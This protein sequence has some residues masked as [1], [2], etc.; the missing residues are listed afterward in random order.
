MQTRPQSQRGAAAV[1]VAILSL[2][3]FLFL[4]LCIEGARALYVWNAIQEVTRRAARLAT[5]TDFTDA[6]KLDGVRITALMPPDGKLPLAPEIQSAALR[7]DYLQMSE[8]GSMSVLSSLPACPA[9]N[10]LNCLSDPYGSNCI[11]LVRA[12]LCKEGASNCTGLDYTPLFG[13]FN[14]YLGGAITLPTA[15]TTVPAQSLGYQPGSNACP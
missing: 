6:A 8:N 1:E 11:R 10:K 5:V 9:Q 2:V 12:S 7:I 14:S 3:F 15:S 4:L 13:F